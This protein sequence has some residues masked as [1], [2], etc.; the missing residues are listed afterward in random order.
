MARHSLRLRGGGSFQTERRAPAAARPLMLPL[1]GPSPFVTE[2]AVSESTRKRVS[3]L[4]F[5]FSTSAFLDPEAGLHVAACLLC[6]NYG[7]TFF[8]GSFTDVEEKVAER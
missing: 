8:L 3:L 7:T 6:R 4:L 5:R 2:G 1:S